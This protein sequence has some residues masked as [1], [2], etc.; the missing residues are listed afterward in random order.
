MQGGSEKDIGLIP[1]SLFEIFRNR[2]NK[3]V[4]ISFIEIREKETVTDLLA[5]NQGETKTNEG[6]IFNPPL[7]ETEIDKEE[8]ILDVKIIIIKFFKYFIE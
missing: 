8:A 1:Q 3:K 2:G 4:F 5:A 7:V 6:Q